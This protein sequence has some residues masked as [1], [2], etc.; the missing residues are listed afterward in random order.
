MT[1]EDKLNLITAALVLG[2]IELGNDEYR[3]NKEQLCQLAS[4]IAASS[5]EQ[6]MKEP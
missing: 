1:E 4:L 3:C 6:F 2:F 5:I